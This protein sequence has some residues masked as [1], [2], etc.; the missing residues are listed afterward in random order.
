[1][2]TEAPTVSGP[3]WSTVATGVWPSA[4][5]VLDNEFG[6][7]RLARH[8][9]FLT[10]ARESGRLTYAALNWPPLAWIFREPSRMDYLDRYAFALDRSDAITTTS[11]IDAL[12]GGEDYAASYIYLGTPDETAHDLGTGPE[13]VA[14]I[15]DAD[16]HLGEILAAIRSRPHYATEEWT[17][18]VVTDHGHRDG[19]GHGER[20]EWERTAWLA[21]CGPRVVVPAEID[22]ASVAPSVLAAL[23]LA[24][25]L[26]G[27]PFVKR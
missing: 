22:H 5:G 24:T 10:L 18:V 8:P 11:A 1:L 15:E 23:G 12:G 9:D 4:H 3:T 27:T 26:T 21:A 13:Y 14:S 25:E 7:H 20:S 16:R 2:S 19:G 6:D 17:F